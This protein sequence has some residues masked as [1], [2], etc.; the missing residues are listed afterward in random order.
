MGSCSTNQDTTMKRSQ[1]ILL[2]ASLSLLASSFAMAQGREWR[3]DHRHR[4]DRHAEVYHDHHRHDGPPP[5][6]VVVRERGAGPNHNFYRG[7]HLPREYQSRRYVVN[8]WRGHHLSA[9]P[10]GYQWVQTG[11]DYVLAAIV[12]GVIAQV[13]LSQ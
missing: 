3:D 4:D 9:P 10:R 11:N 13:L 6:V 1:S 7:G 5:R 12:G 8:D 2:G